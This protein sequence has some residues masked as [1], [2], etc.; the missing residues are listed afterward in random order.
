MKNL[1][2]VILCLAVLYMFPSLF[3]LVLVVVF[4]AGLIGRLN[5]PVSPDNRK[6][7]AVQHAQSEKRAMAG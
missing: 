7:G 5:H 4:V 6:N 2:L 3:L 1:T